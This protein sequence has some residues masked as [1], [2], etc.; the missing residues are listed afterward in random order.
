MI[1][2]SFIL[3]PNLT[4]DQV[5]AMIQQREAHRRKLADTLLAATEKGLATFPPEA[6]I[7]FVDRMASL[8]GLVLG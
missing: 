7:D 2:L 3:N 4:L 6:H 8:A 5:N 1:G